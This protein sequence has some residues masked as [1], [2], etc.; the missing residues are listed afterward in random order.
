MSTIVDD[1]IPASELAHH[2]RFRRRPSFKSNDIAFQKA[3]ALC[4]FQFW[5]V[6]IMNT[7]LRRLRHDSPIFTDKLGSINCGRHLTDHRASAR[8]YQVP[9]VQGV[10]LRQHLVCY[11][12][13]SATFSRPTRPTEFLAGTVATIGRP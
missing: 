1:I 10:V 12:F 5:V 2:I 13:T 8:P 6:Y 3:A 4:R 9:E 11:M 7:G